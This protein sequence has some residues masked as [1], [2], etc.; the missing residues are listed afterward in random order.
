MLDRQGMDAQSASVHLEE[1][2]GEK[3]QP[4]YF[5]PDLHLSPLIPVFVVFYKVSL[6]HQGCK[7]SQTIE[8]YSVRIG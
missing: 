3:S 8:C 4:I 7:S 5:S 6:Q 2:Q 1:K